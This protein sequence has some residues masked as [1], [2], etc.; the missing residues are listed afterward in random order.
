MRELSYTVTDKHDL[1]AKT[2]LDIIR[3]AGAY[4]CRTYVSKNNY[5]TDIDKLFIFLSYGIAKGD[6]I[7]F[8]TDGLD[9]KPAIDKIDNY[10]TS[11]LKN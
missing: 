7:K 4:N 5:I 9:E 11:N 10:I 8:I 6:T 3:L 1:A 2:A